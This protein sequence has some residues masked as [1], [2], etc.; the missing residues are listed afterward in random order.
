MAYIINN[1]TMRPVRKQ[2]MEIWFQFL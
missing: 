1:H 2:Y